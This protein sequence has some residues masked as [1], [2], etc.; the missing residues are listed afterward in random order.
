VSLQQLKWPVSFRNGGRLHFGTVADIKSESVAG[1]RRYSHSIALDLLES[2]RRDRLRLLATDALHKGG[3]NNPAGR[4]P[5]L[6][7]TLIV[8]QQS[9]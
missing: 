3:S 6:W 4:T 2:K 7:D 8:E 1:L 5:W 9:V